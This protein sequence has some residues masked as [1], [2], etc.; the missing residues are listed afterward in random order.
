MRH[1][2]TGA[3]GEQIAAAYLEVQGYD[4]VARGIRVAGVQVDLLARRGATL[5]LVEVKLRATAR[6]VAADSLGAPQRRRLRRAAHA[7][8]AREPGVDCVR[9]DAVGID[10]ER[11]GLTLQHWTGLGAGD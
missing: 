11:H 1:P 9:M 7:L 10:V 2:R 3:L 8:L 6:A 5:V 4:I